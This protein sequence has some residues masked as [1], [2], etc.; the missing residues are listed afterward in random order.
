SIK[1]GQ[2]Q[3][4][5]KWPCYAKVLITFRS[6]LL[7]YS[8]IGLSCCM[9]GDHLPASIPPSMALPSFDVDEGVHI[10]MI[11]I[12][13]WVAD[14]VAMEIDEHGRMY[15]VEMHGYPL[16]KSGSG[17]IKLLGDDDGDGKMDKST[18]FAEGLTLP[19][20]ILRWKK[21]VMVTD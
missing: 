11:A 9:H 19:T 1:S 4:I 15:V 17:K 21:G 20:G 10:E 13:P 18:I 3:W 2:L 16:D 12:E 6:L 8:L 5:Q 14:P 7:S